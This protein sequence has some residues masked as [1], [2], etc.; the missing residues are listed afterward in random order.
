MT[1]LTIESVKKELAGEST[2]NLI[3]LWN[4]TLSSAALDLPGNGK[5]VNQAVGE[6]LKWI[7]VKVKPGKLLNR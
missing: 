2:E 3:S 6:L 7:G 1:Q 5:I 4:V